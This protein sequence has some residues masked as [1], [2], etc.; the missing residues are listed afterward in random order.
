M[1]VLLVSP[2]TPQT[3]WSFGYLLPLLSKKA[4]F[5]PLGLL[6]VAAMLPR[7]W[8][9][10]LIDLNTRRLTDADLGW[11]DAVFLS[12]MIVHEAS[13]REVIARAK[14]AGR[15]VVAGGPLFTTRP[16]RFP[17]VDRCVVGE[18]EDVI[19]ELVADMEAGRARRVYRSE[20][21]PDLSRTPIPRWDLLRLN[22]YA[23]MPV[24]FSRGCPFDCEFCDITTVYGRVPRVKS[25]GQVIGEFEAL[26][27]AGWKGHIFVVD[28]NFIGNR[29]R[30]KGLLRAI[31][32]WR[33]RTGAHMT[34][35]TEASLNLADDGDLMD[36]MV[37]AGFK[38][39]FV[40]IE[41]PEEESLLECRKVQN[42]NRNLLESVR[43]LQ[44]RGME[45]MGG[46]IIGFDSDRPSIFEAQRR[47]IQES[48]IATAMVGLLT[49]LPGTRLF[50]RLTAEG[51]MLGE[52]SGDNLD[53]AMNFV[54]RLDR[55]RLVEGYRELVRTLY[56]PREYYQ[57]ILTFLR[58]YRP[59][60]PPIRMGSEDVKAFVRSLWV[61]G[62]R[63]PGRLRYW[64]FLTRSAVF[65]REVF[66]EAMMLAI[67][68]YH[69]RRVAAEI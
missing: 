50:T 12:A 28:D 32:A 38:R 48:G 46:F 25:A 23:T 16:E 47:F 42:T 51:R 7:E 40:G 26:L 44:R 2:R 30:V 53:T 6:T 64:R 13:A 57:R 11:A 60:G 9:L 10:R 4:A 27:A 19:G 66:G 20:V 58:E 52:S 14:E 34:F 15:P 1:R 24:Q 31:I 63:N 65:H 43:L 67:M 36:L 49:V 59:A 22:D 61:L 5:P 18:A 35:T 55:E 41:S 69:Y 37:R 29:A 33:E 3:F 62:L 54:T 39:V 45:V 8:E 17:E 68:G 21:R 56:A